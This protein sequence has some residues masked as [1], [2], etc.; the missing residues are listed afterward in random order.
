MSTRTAPACSWWTSY[1]KKLFM[2]NAA[3][4]QVISTLALGSAP[5]A[6]GRF[7]GPLPVTITGNV[8]QDGNPLSGV[9][10]TLNGEGILRT[11]LTP[12]AGDFI[13]ALKPGNYSLT[14][15]LSNLAFSPEKMDLQVDPKVKPGST[16]RSPASCRRRP[17]P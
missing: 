11:K 16:S 4:G 2:V 9:T 8:R 7:I 5:V 1:A 10:M 6:V 13:F 15:T 14:P 3:D 12:A 17:S